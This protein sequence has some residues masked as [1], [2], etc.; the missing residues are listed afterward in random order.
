MV[1]ELWGW[2]SGARFGVQVFIINLEIFLGQVVLQL[3]DASRE[4]ACLMEANG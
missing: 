4:A 2:R 3:L 1:L